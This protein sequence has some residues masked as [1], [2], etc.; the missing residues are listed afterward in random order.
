MNMPFIQLNSVSRWYGEESTRVR[1]LTDISLSLPSGT[2]V[3]LVGP[4]GS[5][6]TTLL[7][8]IGALDRPTHGSIIVAEE[9]ISDYDERQ[10]SEF[11]RTKVGFVFQDDA[12]LPEL[13]VAENVELPLVLL[14]TEPKER[15]LQVTEL[16]QS[17]GLGERQQAYPSQ[18]SGGEKQRAAVARAVIH[19]PQILLADEPTANLDAKSAA[20]VLQIIRQ[21]AEQ[22]ELTVLISTHDPRVF[23]LFDRQI[24]LN[25]GQ[26][27]QQPSV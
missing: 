15:H 3:A 11:R 22:K 19:R 9:I 7:N 20:T 1:A 14:G 25:D 24:H 26:L 5:G 27:E 6:K 17:L 10:A 12:L 18:L 16:L 8:L 2:Q 23:K 4:S 13:T 21:L